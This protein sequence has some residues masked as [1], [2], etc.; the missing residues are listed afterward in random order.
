[1]PMSTT[2]VYNKFKGKGMLYMKNII[3]VT[4]NKSRRATII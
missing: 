2:V 4:T 1:M 3:I